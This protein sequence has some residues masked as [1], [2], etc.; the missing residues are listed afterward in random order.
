MKNKRPPEIRRA[1]GVRG[2][3]DSLNFIKRLVGVLRDLEHENSI[4]IGNQL[5]AVCEATPGREI[6]GETSRT[7]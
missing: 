3:L 6:S 4:V 2:R 5:Q 7:F 1:C